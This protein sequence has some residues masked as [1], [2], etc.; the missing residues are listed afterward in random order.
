ME[1]LN[2]PSTKSEILQVEIGYITVIVLMFPTDHYSYNEPLFPRS[3]FSQFFIS[4]VSST[5]EVPTQ[6]HST[7]FF[8]RGRR[9]WC[10]NSNKIHHLPHHV[11]VIVNL[12]VNPVGCSVFQHSFSCLAFDFCDH[13]RLMYNLRDPLHIAPAKVWFGD[14]YKANSFDGRVRKHQQI[15]HRQKDLQYL[16]FFSCFTYTIK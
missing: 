11:T 16:T 15:Y 10:F 4:C 14:V 3:P 2:I 8:R 13:R 6:F 5:L 7:N 9:V 12:I 1:L